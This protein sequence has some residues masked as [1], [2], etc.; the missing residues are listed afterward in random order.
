MNLK[1]YF[2]RH[3]WETHD[4]QVHITGEYG[5]TQKRGLVRFSKCSKCDLSKEYWVYYTHKRE[6]FWKY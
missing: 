1:K 4:K 3:D 6:G 5:I 2:C